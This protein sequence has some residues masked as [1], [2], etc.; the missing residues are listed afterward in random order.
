METPE[1]EW[2]GYIK[3]YEGGTLME[4][5]I[6]HHFRYTNFREILTQQKAFLSSK[7]RLL[8]PS[9][10]PYLLETLMRIRSRKQQLGSVEETESD[11][12]N[13]VPGVLE[14]CWCKVNEGR[15]QG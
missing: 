3:A 7:I 6:D 9:S 13:G 11:S 14:N 1:K 2:S 15:L 10:V 8:I 4:C 5:R 12:L